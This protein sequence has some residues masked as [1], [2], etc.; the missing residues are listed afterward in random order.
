VAPF[1]EVGEQHLVRIASVV[2]RAFAR[3]A[4][5]EQKATA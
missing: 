4:L 1:S 3:D 2:E 5:E